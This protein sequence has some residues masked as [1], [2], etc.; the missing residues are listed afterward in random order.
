VLQR[1]PRTYRIWFLVGSILLDEEHV[2]KTISNKHIEG[3]KG[4]LPLC[5]PFV[6]ERAVFGLG[7]NHVH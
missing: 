7:M 4:K 6:D 5:L 3:N 1:E 2:A